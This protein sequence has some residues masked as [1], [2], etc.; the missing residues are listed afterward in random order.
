MAYAYFQWDRKVEQTERAV[1]A[2][3]L[4][5]LVPDSASLLQSIESMK[6]K[7]HAEPSAEDLEKVLMSHGQPPKRDQ[8][9]ITLQSP[10]RFL[11]FIDALDE[12]TTETR[13]SLARLIDRLDP[14]FF[15]ILITSREDL[16]ILTDPEHTKEIIVAADKDDLE[17]FI[18]KTL[19][20]YLLERQLDFLFET[21]TSLLNTLVNEIRERAN[22]M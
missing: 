10:A 21:D 12:A 13:Q 6:E 5:K 3:L 16:R 2:S 4:H 9:V 15:R 14:R 19:E 7:L 8:G 22:D 1:L 17:L 18:S 11:I 20:D